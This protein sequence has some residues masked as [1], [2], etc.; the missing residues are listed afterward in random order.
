MRSK[1]GADM[2]TRIFLP[3]LLG[4]HPLGA[5]ASFGLLRLATQWDSSTRLAFV[6]QDDWVAVLESNDQSS[7]DAL[8]S[9]LVKWIAT[10][11]VDRTLQWADDVRV[12]RGEY[13]RVLESALSENDLVLVEFLGAIAADGAVDRQKGLIKPCSFYM[14]SGQ[15]SFLKGAKEVV[16]AIRT[17]PESMFR[18]ALEG[19]WKYQTRVHGLGWDPN[20]ERLYALRH[21]APTSE[22]PSCVAGA[23]VLALWALALFPTVSDS[24][25]ALTTGFTRRN[26][27]QFFSWPV[28]STP[29][30]LTELTSLLQTGE[31]AWRSQE[32]ILRPGIEACYTSRRFEFGQGYAVFRPPQ[33]VN[34]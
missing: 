6:L 27:Q 11:D 23:V 31:I 25:K 10:D 1:I 34:R 3:A 17:S 29:I 26:S 18:E 5:L 13:Q 20:T 32:G 4:S 33:A 9:N 28:F 19:P 22:K 12:P 21:K 16:A 30:Q 24:G 2:G 7:T 15:Q 8:I 14:V